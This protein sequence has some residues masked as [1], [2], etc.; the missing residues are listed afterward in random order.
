M[1]RTRRHLITAIIVVVLAVVAI[2]N[3]WSSSPSFG[4]DLYNLFS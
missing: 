1:T 4:Y 3:A 2:L